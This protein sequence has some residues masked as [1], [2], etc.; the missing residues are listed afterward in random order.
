[1]IDPTGVIISLL[2]ADAAVAAIAGTKVRGG[3]LAQ[4]DRPP[5]VIVARITAN[6][7][8]GGGGSRRI[9][10]QEVLLQIKCL[11]ATRMQAAQLYG[12]CSDAV[13]MH[14]PFEDE[15]GRAI[16]TIADDVGVTSGIDPGTSWPYE[17]GTVRVIAAA[18]AAA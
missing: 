17:D 11:G 5:A 14:A 6:R 1:M 15:S 9:G 16:F 7:N 18:E 13:H 12:A 2:K 3:E 10:L 8:P 4:G